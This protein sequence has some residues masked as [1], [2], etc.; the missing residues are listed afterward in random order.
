MAAKK[1][2]Q[3]IAIFD[4]ELAA[5]AE[6]F[7]QMEKSS[8]ERQFF[9]AQGG[10]LTFDGD[11]IDNNMM[12]VVILDSVFENTYYPGEYDPEV[13]SSPV[14]FAFAR[15]EGELQPDAMASEAQCETCAACPQNKFGSA[16][17]GKG[18]ACKNT[19]RLVMI[20]AGSFD[21]NQ[22]FEAYEDV[23]HFK[24]AGQAYMRLPVTSVAN[25]ATYVKQLATAA[26]RPP[27]GVFT[28][29]YLTRDQKTQ[30]KVNFEL[31][32]NVPNAVMGEVMKRR[33]VAAADIMF[34]YQPFEAVEEKPAKKSRQATAAKAKASGK[35]AP[36]KADGGKKRRF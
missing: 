26:R 14:C 33:E 6:Q 13:K 29:I 7:R 2:K 15:D 24:T 12:A 8:G 31:L 28:K 16:D 11:E 34:P 3:E 25:Y 32:G 17:V 22:Q 27:F 21:K 19:R 10:I 5:A 18:K 1:S 36:A 20:P 4:E 30:F 9:G 35:A 23:E